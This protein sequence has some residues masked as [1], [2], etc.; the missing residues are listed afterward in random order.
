MGSCRAIQTL[1]TPQRMPDSPHEEQGEQ[2][3]IRSLSSNE[4]LG[5]SRSNNI[6]RTNEF[7][8]SETTPPIAP[9]MPPPIPEKFEENFPKILQI[10]EQQY[11][12]FSNA[13]FR[14]FKHIFFQTGGPRREAQNNPD[15]YYPIKRIIDHRI[16]ENGKGLEFSVEWETENETPCLTWNDEEGLDFAGGAILAY[17]PVRDALMS[18]AKNAIGDHASR[19]MSGNPP[20][21]RRVAPKK[22]PR[23]KIAKKGL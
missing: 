22:A 13:P 2:Y 16:S 15:E 9:L 21:F 12:N 6:L 5:L 20:F 19:R 4:E 23:K 7:V 8:P 18:K 17:A 3:F 11:M 10:L 1:L 14:K